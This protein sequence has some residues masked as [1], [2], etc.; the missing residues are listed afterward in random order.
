MFLSH[1]PKLRI[2]SRGAWAY[3]AIVNFTTASLEPAAA[4]SG[5]KSGSLPIT[6]TPT[7]VQCAAAMWG[8]YPSGV[9][10]EQTGQPNKYTVFC[11]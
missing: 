9:Q 1:I 10:S 4:S 2:K 5:W 11:F 8:G 7:M 6:L 3:P